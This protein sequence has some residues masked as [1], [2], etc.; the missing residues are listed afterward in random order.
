PLGRHD[1]AVERVEERRLVVAGDEAEVLH[2]TA[3]LGRHLAVH[4]AAAGDPEPGPTRGKPPEGFDQRGYTLVRRELAEIAVYRHRSGRATVG[5]SASAVGQ[6][7]YADAISELGDAFVLA[8]RRLRHAQ[9][10]LRPAPSQL[11][12][13]DGGDG[14]ARPALVDTRA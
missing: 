13:S 1:E 5:A 8:R 6:V 9:H 2:V 11:A 7:Q 4:R 12:P 10:H 3:R 14:A